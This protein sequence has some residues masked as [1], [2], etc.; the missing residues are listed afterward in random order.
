RFPGRKIQTDIDDDMHVYG[1]ETLIYLLLINLMENAW[2]YT[3]NRSVAEI[4]IGQLNH[5]EKP[6]IYIKDNGIGFD[7]K[8]VERLF[9][10][11]QRLDN[12]AEHEGTGIGLA[13]ARRILDRDGGKIWADAKPD[14]GARFYFQ[15]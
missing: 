6:V 10:I 15:I 4:T 13:S 14:P 3:K 7:K 2:K 9:E 8:Y 12:S 5:Q 11:F 1:S